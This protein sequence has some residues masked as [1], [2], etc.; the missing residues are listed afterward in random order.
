MVLS[1]K[2]LSGL[3][4]AVLDLM[5]EASDRLIVPRFR[6]LAA[7]DIKTKSS[8]TDLVTIADIETEQWLTPRLAELLPGSMVV[9][10]EAVAEDRSGSVLAR[11]ASDVPV[12]VIDPVD[13]TRNFAQGRETFVTMLALVYQQQPLLGMIWQPVK[14]QLF[15]AIEGQGAWMQP[16]AG[17]RR[18]LS[19]RKSAPR[20]ADLAGTI[21]F[22][23]LH[24]ADQDPARANAAK[25]LK[26]DCLGCAGETYVRLADGRYDFAVF[27]LL[28]A[29][30]HC[31]GLIILREAG[32]VDILSDGSLY[33]TSWQQDRLI[34]A[35]NRHTADLVEA[36]LFA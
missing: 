29:W 15:W 36:E 26:T 11:L 31:P 17:E 25:F 19:T 34:L 28:N 7:N 13:G 1:D 23:W 9:G 27:G 20:P 21:S 35:S 5:V 2:T 6:S 10:E 16:E 24:Q 3:V 33:N 22:K 18:R 4:P 14:R 8:P 12:W 32:G 30:D